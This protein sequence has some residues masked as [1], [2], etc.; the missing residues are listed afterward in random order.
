MLTPSTKLRLPTLRRQLVSRPRL[1]DL[2]SASG[3]AVR[4]LLIAA[5]AG[6]G[7]TTLLN[8]YLTANTDSTQARATVAWVTLDEG[9]RDVRRFLANLMSA[10]SGA[11][12]GAGS[13]ALAMLESSRSSNTEDILASLINDLDEIDGRTFVALDDFHLADAPAVHAAVTFLVDHLPP[14]ATLAITTRADPQL[15]LAR[16][17]TR[18]ELIEIRASDLRFTQDEAETFLNSVMGLHLGPAQVSTLEERTEGWAAGL[19]LAALSVR[20]REST[21]EPNASSEFVEAF[22]G[23]HRFV[24]DYLIEEVLANQTPEIRQFLIQTSVLGEMTGALC[25]RV[26][27]GKNGPEILEALDRGNVFLV[28]LDEQR[29]WYRYHHLFADA[30]RARLPAEC[31]TPTSNLHA[32]ASDWF[33]EHAMFNDALTHASASGDAKR[34][35]D[36]AELGLS[37]LRKRRQ[38]QT[39][40]DWLDK[41]SDEEI[42]AR[43]LLATAKAWSRLI[44]GDL[45]GVDG[46]L[47]TAENQLRTTLKQTHWSG[48]AQLRDA[49]KDRDREVRSL[50]TTIAIYRASVAQARGDIEGTVLNARHAQEIAQPDDL[51]SLGAAAGFLGLAAWADGDLQTAVETFGQAVVHLNLAGNLTDELGATVVLASMS[52]ALGRPDRA[53]ELYTRALVAAEENPGSAISILGD[54][55]VG[56]ADILREGGEIE[57]AARQL[58]LARELGD[59]GSLPENRYRWYAATA[60]LCVAEGNLDVAIEMYATAERTYLHGFFPDVRPI[61]ASKARV[62]ILQNKLENART[63]WT[64][65]PSTEDSTTYLDEYNDLTV[66]RLQIAEQRASRDVNQ[67]ADKA[68]ALLDRVADS[69]AG[70]LGTLI[71]TAMLRGLAYQSSGDHQAA[72][73]SL[74]M[75]ITQGVPVGYR[76]LF[77]DEGQ[78]LT[79]LLRELARSTNDDLVR[80]NA[81]RLLASAKPRKT[82]ASAVNPTDPDSLSERELEV[83]RLLPTDLSGPEIARRLFISVNTLR[84][85]TKRIFTKLDVNTRRAA[86]SRARELDLL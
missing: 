62:W 17:R 51:L 11:T 14:R 85:H 52:L 40:V 38:D 7:K 18:G 29:R 84:T 64:E 36:I 23:S 82:T 57:A 68:L 21:G 76:R 54:M 72:L 6:F 61:A 13:E 63:W 49:T 45:D 20:A 2:A 74:S 73:L 24:L 41:I 66:V 37:E 56:L 86:V 55:H 79:D 27:G 5:P 65:H 78:P 83:L 4:L 42:R 71:E 3:S 32:R 59:R 58:A 31:A 69:A 22:G 80:E 1:L 77:L 33:V 39:I 19:Q 81:L 75:A 25:D 44:Q 43:P 67:P 47:D 30:L 16:L 53:G 8:Q 26:T 70:R 34:T 46:W 48:S 28:A 9:D 10:V 50:P 35:A 12:D 15:P 60:A